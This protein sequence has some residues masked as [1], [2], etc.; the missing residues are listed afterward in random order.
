MRTLREEVLPPSERLYVLALVV[1]YAESVHEAVQAVS[2]R[3]GA[4]RSGS[5]VDG[6]VRIAAGT[7]A[8]ALAEAI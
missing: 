4:G 2:G 6:T 8:M 1:S 7:D 5:G 3:S